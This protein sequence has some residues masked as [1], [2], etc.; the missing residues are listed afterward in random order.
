MFHTSPAADSQFGALGRHC[1]AM[2]G[3][4]TIRTFSPEDPIELDSFVF[5]WYTCT[6]SNAGCFYFN[7]Y[8]GCL[9]R[10]ARA[11]C[12]AGQAAPMLLTHC[13]AAC[14]PDCNVESQPA[15]TSLRTSQGPLKLIWR[16][17]RLISSHVPC[18]ADDRCFPDLHIHQSKR[19]M[20]YKLIQH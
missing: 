3:I 6:L 20:P 14:T 8:W 17:M 19:F 16:T 2:L 1:S 18:C 15:R 13:A 11:A 7:V 10:C 9:P 4:Y 5:P 12:T